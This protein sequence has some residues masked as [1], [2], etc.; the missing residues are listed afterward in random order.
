MQ[1]HDA[2]ELLRGNDVQYTL[3]TARVESNAASSE[4]GV[5]SL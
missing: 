4:Y 5:A 2:D 1:K 3:F